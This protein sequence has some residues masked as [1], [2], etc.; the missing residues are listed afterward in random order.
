MTLQKERTFVKRKHCR[1]L[2]QDAN[3][4][5]VICVKTN[6]CRFVTNKQK[7]RK[8]K[9]KFKI[10]H[11]QACCTDRY[12][13]FH[14]YTHTPYNTNL[15]ETHKDKTSKTFVKKKAYSGNNKLIVRAP[16]EWPQH[17]SF[18]VE[19]FIPAFLST[20]INLCTTTI[21]R[22]CCVCTMNESLRKVQLALVAIWNCFIEILAER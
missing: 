16:T 14:T 7:K 11:S 4:M 8:R 12:E 10:V 3:R 9:T 2:L 17:I 20:S 6:T 13:V 21:G 22:V 5:E 18:A 1:I 15:Y 19:I